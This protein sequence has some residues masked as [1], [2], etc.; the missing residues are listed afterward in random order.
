MLENHAVCRLTVA[1]DVKL[2]VETTKEET[3]TTTLSLLL[4]PHRH[5]THQTGRVSPLTLAAW[6]VRCLLDN[7]R[8]NR[9]E[10]RTS[11]VA[12]KL[13]SNKMDTAAPS[14]TRFSEQGQVEE[15]WSDNNDSVISNLLAEKNR[16]HKAYV[17]S[18]NDENRSAFYRS[19]RLVQQ[20]LR[21]MQDVWT[22]HKAEEIQGY[23][24]RSG[25][26]NFFS[27]SKAVYGPPTKGTAPL[28][29]ADGST[30]L[31]Q[32]TQILQRWSEHFRGILNRPSAISDA[33]I[34]RLLQVETN[35]ELDLP[36]SHPETIRAVK[37]LS[38]GKA[39]G[40]DGSLLRGCQEMRDH[41]HSPFVDLA[42]AFSAVNHDDLWKIMQKFC[43]PE[44]LIQMMRQLHD[45][46]MATDNGA[47][48]QA[49]AVTNGMKQGCVLAPTLFSLMFS[50]MLMDTSRD[51]RSRIRTAYK[52]DGHLLNNRRMHFQSRVF[53]T[54]VHEILLADDFALNTIPGGD[55][56]RSMDHFAT[57]C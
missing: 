12:R 7:L 2:T 18:Y 13:A 55:M 28:F 15:D 38:R 22:A 25:C 54:T 23:A 34:A 56:Q 52:T 5:P 1:A 35:A 39:P 48:S 9:P 11:L 3:T 24:D 21:E 6:N 53:T 36:P 49:S 10:R 8:C 51:E 20:R 29:S 47:V 4:L 43:C 32:E 26:K 42:K 17:E 40:S 27:A 31:T 14:E 16:L 19:R 50:A 41:L 33:G 57:A 30:L 44:R 45:C 46:M 37:Q